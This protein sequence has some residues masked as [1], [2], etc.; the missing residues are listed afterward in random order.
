MFAHWASFIGTSRQIWANF[1]VSFAITDVTN[2]DMNNSQLFCDG[3]I[4]FSAFEDIFDVL[5]SK[6]PV[7]RGS[8]FFHVTSVVH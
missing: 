8:L 7:A 1:A 3:A 4:R 6:A 5:R 2:Y